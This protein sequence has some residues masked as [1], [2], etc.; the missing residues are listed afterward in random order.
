MGEIGEEMSYPISGCL[1]SKAGRGDEEAFKELCDRMEYNLT[2]PA[3]SQIPCRCNP[4]CPEPTKEQLDTM[5]KRL[6][7]V[8]DERFRKKE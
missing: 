8:L 4:P 1:V 3:W 6:K 5:N 7:E 2:Q